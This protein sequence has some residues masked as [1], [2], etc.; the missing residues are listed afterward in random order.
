MINPEVS[1]SVPYF[2]QMLKKSLPAS[3]LGLKA[4]V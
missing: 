3:A 1:N 2:S 4:S